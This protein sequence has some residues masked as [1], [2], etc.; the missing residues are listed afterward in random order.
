MLGVLNLGI[1]WQIKLVIFGQTWKCF[2]WPHKTHQGNACWGWA[3]ATT[4]PNLISKSVNLPDLTAIFEFHSNPSIFN[5]I[6]YLQT[7]KALQQCAIKAASVTPTWMICS[8]PGW[9]MWLHACC[10]PL[11]LEKDTWGYLIPVWEQLISFMQKQGV[12]NNMSSVCSA[13]STLT[14]LPSREVKL[15]KMRWG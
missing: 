5:E 8:P 4:T 15:W 9:R 11:E 12:K 1:L 13:E 6:F 3:S 2:A 14:L 7:L 10:L